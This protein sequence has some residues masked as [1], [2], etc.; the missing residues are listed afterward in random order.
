MEWFEFI[1]LI[2]ALIIIIKFIMEISIKGYVAM[3]SKEAKL[4]KHQAKL[5][6]LNKS[7]AKLQNKK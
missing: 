6:K 1:F 5:D 7:L 3:F 2:A 4:A